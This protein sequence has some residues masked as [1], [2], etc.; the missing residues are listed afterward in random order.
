M[1]PQILFPWLVCL[2]LGTSHLSTYYYVL[3]LPE[4]CP[5]SLRS[6]PG[7]PPLAWPLGVQSR[8]HYLLAHGGA[9]PHPPAHLACDPRP[10]TP[11]ISCGS[12]FSSSGLL[13]FACPVPSCAPPLLWLALASPAGGCVLLYSQPG[14]LKNKRDGERVQRRPCAH[15]VSSVREFSRVPQPYY[16]S[17]SF[18]TFVC[19]HG[20]CGLRLC[21]SAHVEELCGLSSLLSLSHT[22]SL[23]LGILGRGS[24][25]KPCP[26]LLTGGSR[27][28]LCP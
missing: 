4:A 13:L 7:E 24:T 10:F 6:H 21:C 9:Q 12:L 22:S 18:S 5:R 1:G 28:G 20:L 19:V 17:F 26:Q 2:C 27:Q 11:T 25:P 3:S 14:L 15:T 23:S 16:S 8:C